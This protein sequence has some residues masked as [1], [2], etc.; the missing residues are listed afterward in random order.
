VNAYI[1]VFFVRHATIRSTDVGQSKAK[2]A[3]SFIMSRIPDVQ[4]TPHFCKIQDFDQ[5]FYAQFTLIICGLDSVEARR[6]I[7]ATIVNMYDEEHPET[8]KP[9]IDGGT[10]GRVYISFSRN[11]TKKHWNLKK[12]SKDKPESFFQG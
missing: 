2:V 12:A 10:E 11:T 5:D 8:L 7:N 4:V 1:G 3:A 9:I 6:W